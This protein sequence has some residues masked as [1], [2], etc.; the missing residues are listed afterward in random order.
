MDV[1]VAVDDQLGAVP[2][3][4]RAQVRA[5]DQ[6]LEVPRRSLIGGW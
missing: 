6:P 3:Q 5:V 2:R 4:R 1:I